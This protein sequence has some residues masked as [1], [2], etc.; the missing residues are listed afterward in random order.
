MDILP[1]G[2]KYSRPAPVTVRVGNL[3][4]FPEGIPIG[5]ARH[6]MEEAVRALARDDGASQV[7]A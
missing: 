4:T 7:A 5:E 3:L 1:P 6:S 2:T